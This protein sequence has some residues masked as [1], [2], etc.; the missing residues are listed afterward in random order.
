MAQRLTTEERSRYARVYEEAV[1]EAI[2]EALKVNCKHDGGFRP[3]TGTV[4]ITVSDE[5]FARWLIRS[6]GWRKA[7]DGG[8]GTEVNLLSVGRLSGASNSITVKKAFA[9]GFRQA[10]Y[11]ATAGS[12]RATST[13][14]E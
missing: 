3:S 4:I 7:E 6:A 11:M 1:E 14:T 2:E 9:R 10:L 8:A 5:Q 13:V 12:L